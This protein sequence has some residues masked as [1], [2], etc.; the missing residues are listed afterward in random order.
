MVDP[1]RSRIMKSIRS[2]D[3]TP[4]LFI[5]RLVHRRGFRFR[6]HSS[7]LPGRPD[8]VLA[9]YR[10]LIFVNG[11]FWH[12]HDCHIYNPAK[13]RPPAW[14][15]KIERNRK[16][17]QVNLAACNELGWKYVIVWECAIQGRT[18]IDPE[19]IQQ[20]ISDWLCG[21]STNLTISGLVE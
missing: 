3:T 18:K 1:V 4:E 14:E 20:K 5:R 2:K 12:G 7:K 8:L 11:C 13:R 10:A 15:D 21:N 17:D 9:K 19:A 16:R 6:L